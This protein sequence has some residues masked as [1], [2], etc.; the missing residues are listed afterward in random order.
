MNQ[1]KPD[2]QSE[3][4]DKDRFYDSINYFEFKED[5]WNFTLSDQN[6]REKIE[7]TKKKLLNKVKVELAKINNQEL[8]GDREELIIGYIK[9][10]I[11]FIKIAYSK[12]RLLIVAPDSDGNHYPYRLIEKTNSMRNEAYEYYLKYVL[13]KLFDFSINEENVFRPQNISL[14]ITGVLNRIKSFLEQH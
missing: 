2:Y 6:L 9:D 7:K 11:S 12:D 5:S 4:Y 10:F 13:G 1:F 3:N 14:N 8:K